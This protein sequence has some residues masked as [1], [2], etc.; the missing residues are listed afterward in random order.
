P[1]R[2][3]VAERRQEAPTGPA[4]A[5]LGV[6]RGVPAGPVERGHAARPGRLPL[7]PVVGGI[8]LARDDEHLARADPLHGRLGDRLAARGGRPPRAAQAP[9][10]ASPRPSVTPAPSPRHS[11]GLPSVPTRYSSASA[12]RATPPSFP[13]TRRLPTFFASR[14]T[15]W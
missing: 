1:L 13:R 11:P 4:R 10:G 2:D 3:G 15:T 5:G 7:G 12:L 6:V 14:C 9:S 8:R